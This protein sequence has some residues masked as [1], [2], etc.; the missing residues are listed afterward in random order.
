MQIGYTRTDAQR[1][2]QYDQ[3]FFIHAPEKR[4]KKTSMKTNCNKTQKKR[5]RKQHPLALFSEKIPF[6]WL[7]SDNRAKYLLTKL[8]NKKDKYILTII[9]VI[10][11]P[12]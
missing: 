2:W 11:V 10:I 6:K 3:T 1:T 5:Y 9:I 12:G 4:E 7:L 8:A